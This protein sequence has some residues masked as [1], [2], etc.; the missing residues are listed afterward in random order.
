MQLGE[1]LIQFGVFLVAL[2]G[3][4]FQ[5]VVFMIKKTK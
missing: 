5:I 1:L 3:L 2:L 4:I